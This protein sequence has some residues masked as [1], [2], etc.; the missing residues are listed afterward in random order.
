MKTRVGSIAQLLFVDLIGSVAWFPVWWYTKGLQMLLQSV[1]R[2]LQY[3]VRAY[4][5]GIWIKNFFV[6]MY[7]QYDWTGRLI[8]VFMRFVVLIG[9]GI[10]I[11]VIAWVYLLGVIAWVLLPPLALLLFFQGGAAGILN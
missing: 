5:F 10:A 8:S 2:A 7:G 6:P 9:R 3:R 1:F 11:T 4:A